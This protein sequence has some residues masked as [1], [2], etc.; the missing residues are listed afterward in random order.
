VVSSMSLVLRRTKRSLGVIHA[1]SFLFS[2]GIIN[3]AS[4]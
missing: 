4:D 1:L 2:I 3:L